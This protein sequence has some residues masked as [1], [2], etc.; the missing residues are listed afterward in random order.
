MAVCEGYPIIKKKTKRNIKKLVFNSNFY[1]GILN[2]NKKGNGFDRFFYACR[3]KEGGEGAKKQ[4]TAVL[5]QNNLHPG[6][7]FDDR[8]QRGRFGFR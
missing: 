6:G 8:E 3:M 4:A 7:L 1:N 5:Y 2:M